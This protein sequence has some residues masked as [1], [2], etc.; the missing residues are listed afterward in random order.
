[1]KSKIEFKLLEDHIYYKSGYKYQLQAR[2]NLKIKLTLL[3]PIDIL[4][5]T[6]ENGILSALPGYAWDGPSGPTVDTKSFMRGSLFHD[7]LYQ[8]MKEGYLSWGYQEYADDLLKDISKT[9]KMFFRRRA[10][11][12]LGVHAFGR[13]WSKISKDKILTAP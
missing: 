8:L 5:V 10:Y 3:R 11:V 2:A 1:M 13:V 12:W 4:F 6:Y 7:V 9:D